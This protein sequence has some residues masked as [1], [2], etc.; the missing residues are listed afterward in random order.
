MRG[1][2]GF[3]LVEMAIVL[4]IIGIILGAVIKGQDL[5]V[6]AQAKQLASAVSSWRNLAFAYYDRNGRFPGDAGRDGIIG[7]NL[8]AANQPTP[9]YETTAA[10]GTGIAELVTD[11]S[12]APANPVIVGGMSFWTYFGNAVVTPVREML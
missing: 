5:V 3:T 4:V 10:T 1:N 12:Y 2:K 11:M 9:T 7:N 8:I 6:N